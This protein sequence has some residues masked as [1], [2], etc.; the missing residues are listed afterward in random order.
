MESVN[1]TR[2]FGALRQRPCGTTCTVSGT[3][4]VLIPFDPSSV[5]AAALTAGAALAA[6]AAEV[7]VSGEGDIRTAPGVRRLSVSGGRGEAV[8]QGVRQLHERLH[9]S[10]GA[11]RLVQSCRSSPCSR[12]PV[13]KDRADV[14]VGTGR[15]RA[16]ALEPSGPGALGSPGPTSARPGAGD[17]D[18][19]AQEPESGLE[20]SRGQR[21]DPR[22]ARSPELPVPGGHAPARRAP[23]A[24]SRR[25]AT[26]SR[27]SCAT[28]CSPMTQ[29][30]HTR[31]T[32][33]SSGS[34]RR[35]T[36][37][38]GSGR[39]SGRI[40]ADGCSRSGRESAR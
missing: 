40:S 24:P 13:L 26:S 14:V 34:S 11:E 31:A 37:T 32:T 6:G 21:R 16:S 35:R 8:Q 30:T 17:P 2:G 36:T 4:S 20:R 38:R 7:V 12:A 39:S 10:A 22:Q 9:R 5:E 27:R 28:R 33:R 18:R 1:S 29:T 3:F 19:G 25:R 23:L 15:E